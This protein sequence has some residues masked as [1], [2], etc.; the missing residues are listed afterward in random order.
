[1]AAGVPAA[2]E[3]GQSVLA[4][5][6]MARVAHVSSPV[7][8]LVA[9]EVVERPCSAI[10]QRPCVTV[11]RIEAVVHVAIE[12]GTAVEP[13]AGSDEQAANKPIGPVVSVG[14]TVIGRVIKV[15]VGARGRHSNSDGNLG[16]RHVGRAAKRNCKSGQ[17]KGLADRQDYSSIF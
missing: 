4:G 3:P 6:I 1:V 5:A 13:G 16:L 12:A 7:A 11:V 17:D 8:G 9:M 14:S 10:R 2:V 15:P